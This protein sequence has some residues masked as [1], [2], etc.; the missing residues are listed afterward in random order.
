MRD[1]GMWS[2]AVEPDSLHGGS[3][4]IF[5]ELVVFDTVDYLCHVWV[6]HGENDIGG[7]GA[8]ASGSLCGR[9]FVAL[10]LLGDLSMNV[11]FC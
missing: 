7:S 5:S 1:A 6:L 8:W 3:D 10:H 9:G 11:E 4:T 2:S